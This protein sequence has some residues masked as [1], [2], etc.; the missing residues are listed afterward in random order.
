MFQTNIQLMMPD[1]GAPTLNTG[2]IG[3]SA[4]HEIVAGAMPDAPAQMWYWNQAYRRSASFPTLSIAYYD[5]ALDAAS[6]MPG[7]T[8]QL[9]SNAAVFR[10][11]WDREDTWVLMDTSHG[12]SRSTHDQPDQ[13]SI[14]IY[15]RKAYLLMDPGDGRNYSDARADWLRSSPVAHNLVTI[16][17]KEGPLG[18][19]PA[20]PQKRFAYAYQPNHE[21]DPAPRT[22]GFVSPYM[23]YAEAAIT[24]YHDAPDVS[25]RRSVLFPNREYV[26][27][28]DEMISA[29][30]HDYT[31]LFHFGGYEG[32]ERIEGSL[33]TGDR[34]A[35]WTTQNVD[36][37]AVELRVVV[38]SPAVAISQHTGPTN[39]R[40]GITLD[41]TYIRLLASRSNV[42]FLTLLL[43]R[44]LAEPDAQWQASGGGGVL[45]FAGYQDTHGIGADG[46]E[47]M[48]G[49]VTA[50][51]AYG[52]V[53][54]AADVVQVVAMK[55]GLRVGYG[56][57]VWLESSVA[58]TAALNMADPAASRVMIADPG[59]GYQLSVMTPA[60]A[61]I[62]QITLDGT[63]HDFTQT[64]AVVTA[65]LDTGGEL[66]LHY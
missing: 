39:L 14:A 36:G 64:G 50:T 63:A 42:I 34:E 44:K 13:T 5:A 48:V 59:Q 24:G 8:S 21:W 43:P 6:S 29:G 35:R 11:G 3:T 1:R 58:L 12:A 22:E 46:A 54:T 9:L 4:M 38:A 45:S 23:D 41:H 47:W 61:T 19:A 15:A 7:Y 66:V 2:W 37:E 49:D 53:R 20:T 55:R 17:G 25:T 40:P 31:Q 16:D 57:L 51:A 33:Q 28:L 60:G 62:S 56:G 26:V 27:L 65:A 30:A 18:S 32:K 10:S 52:Y